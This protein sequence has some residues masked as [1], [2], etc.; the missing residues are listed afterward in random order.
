MDMGLFLTSYSALKLPSHTQRKPAA[1]GEF[2]WPLTSYSVIIHS[3]SNAINRQKGKSTLPL[4]RA[5]AFR[6]TAT[7]CVCHLFEPASTPRHPQ[8]TVIS[9]IQLHLVLPCST[10]GQAARTPHVPPLLGT[11]STGGPLLALPPQCKSSCLLERAVN[12]LVCQMAARC[13][14]K[15]L[16]ASVYL[17][18]SSSLL[19]NSWRN[20]VKTSSKPQI[21]CEM[22]LETIFAD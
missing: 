22:Q 4:G 20:S 7:V 9:K 17:Q 14:N 3:H 16:C 13:L 1:H 8:G 6:K 5:A 10:S 12:W 21:I 2:N 18:R 19:H 15:S 11:R